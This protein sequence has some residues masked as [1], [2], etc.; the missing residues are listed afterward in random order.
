RA[1]ADFYRGGVKPHSGVWRDL[2]VHRRKT[3]VDAQLG[4]VADI[5]AAR[6]IAVPALSGLI[7][8]IH[9]IEEGRAVQ[10]D[11]HLAELAHGLAA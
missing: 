8:L 11:A 10:D 3:E 2:A 1:I 7:A 5:A 6:G 9:R 4:M